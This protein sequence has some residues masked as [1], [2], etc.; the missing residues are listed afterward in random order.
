MKDEFQKLDLLQAKLRNDALKNLHLAIKK[1][2]DDF[3]N[4]TNLRQQII[5]K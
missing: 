1:E 4:T 2:F 5:E 3:Q